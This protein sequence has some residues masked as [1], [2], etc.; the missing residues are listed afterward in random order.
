MKGVMMKKLIALMALA[1]LVAAGCASKENQGGS[2]DNQSNPNYGTGTNNPSENVSPSP[3]SNTGTSGS[4][5]NSNPNSNNT[6][7]DR[8]TPNS[9]NNPSSDQSKEH[10]Q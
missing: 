1:G 6:S 10:A 7:G 2:L 5:N 8:S 4:L 9:G 3:N